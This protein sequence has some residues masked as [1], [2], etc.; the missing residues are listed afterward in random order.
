MLMPSALPCDLSQQQQQRQSTPHTRLQ[1]ALLASPP[2]SPPSLPNQGAIGDIF[3]TCRSLQTLL[4]TPPSGPVDSALATPLPTP[5]LAHAS[6][7]LKLRL[8]P[9]PTKPDGPTDHLPRKKI[10]KRAPPR[11]ANKRRR[12]PHDDLNRHL[13]HDDE[14]NSDS[15]QSDLE[16]SPSPRQYNTHP[17]MPPAPS[18]PKRARIAPE[19][20]PLGLERS[21]YHSLHLLEMSR[22]NDDNT[23]T[24]NMHNRPGARDATREAEPQGTN[25]ELEADGEPWSVE[26]D[27]L[28]VELVLEKLK[29]TKMEWQDCARSLGKDRSAASRRWKSLI[30]K[31]EVGLKGSRATGRSRIHATW[32]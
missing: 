32:R 6:L 20:I 31:N 18:T 3:N 19:V 10:I 8:R 1:A 24:T 29:L 13:V 26:D 25:V 15:S 21:D 5:P 28:L 16:S 27:R 22:S 12:S 7:P 4:A 11:G 2:A 30:S 9:R 14:D 17:D 23:T